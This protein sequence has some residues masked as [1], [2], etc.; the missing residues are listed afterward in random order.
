MSGPLKS[1]PIL[2]V[3]STLHKLLSTMR[4]VLAALPGY[5]GCSNAEER[6]EG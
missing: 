6:V 4:A 1:G 2:G 5:G 3:T